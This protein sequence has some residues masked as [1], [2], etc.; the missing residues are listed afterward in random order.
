MFKISGKR[1]GKAANFAG[2]IQAFACIRRTH[3]TAAG[4]LQQVLH[5]LLAV[6]FAHCVR[7]GHKGQIDK[8]A[9]T[10]VY[11]L[12]NRAVNAASRNIAADQ[13]GGWSRQ[14]P[15]MYAAQSQ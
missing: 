2:D 14:F 6:L 3:I 10:K 5:N 9:Q 13:W 12:Q 15:P 11:H 4:N 1:V 8:K 7:E